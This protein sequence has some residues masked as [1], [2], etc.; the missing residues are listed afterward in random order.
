MDLIDALL[1]ISVTLFL[2][3]FGSMRQILYGKWYVHR[4]TWKWGKDI[5]RLR[6]FAL[7]GDDQ[8]LRQK[9]KTTLNILYLSGGLFL[10]AICIGILH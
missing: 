4:P 2:Y 6:L 7:K 1:I 5:S 10:L 8:E 3:S 9:C